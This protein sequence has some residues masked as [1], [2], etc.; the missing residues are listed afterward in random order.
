M[1]F[2]KIF[3]CEE[4]VVAASI[5]FEFEPKRPLT[6]KPLGIIILLLSVLGGSSLGIISSRLPA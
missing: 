3:K 6:F 5:E 4:V 1:S 2:Q